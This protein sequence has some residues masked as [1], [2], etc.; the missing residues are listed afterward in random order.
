MSRQ[1]DSPIT[2]I[3]GEALAAYRRVKLSVGKAVYA[4]AGEPGVGVTEAAVADA[5]VASIRLLSH[6]GTFKVTAAGT[7]ALNAIL[8]GAA[9]GK[10]D[11]VASG[12]PLFYAAE[13]A[14][15]ANDILEAV[16]VANLDTSDINVL[17]SDMAGVVG[18]SDL[19]ALVSDVVTLKSDKTV[20]ASNITVNASHLTVTRSDLVTAGS[21]VTAL[22]SDAVIYK[23]DIN[24]NASHLVTTRSDVTALQSDRTWT[25]SDIVSEKSDTVVFKSDIAAE[26]SDTVVFKANRT[27]VLKGISDAIL[28]AAAGDYVNVSDIKVSVAEVLKAFSDGLI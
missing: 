7:F 11:D 24:V 5:G 10:V 9:D 20:M 21:H 14:T 8:Y 18:T 17:I 2:L 15:A 19:A 3:A 28:A 1:Q 16:P 4:D 26:K 13:A 23:S 6:G 27:K 22:R 25:R 12:P